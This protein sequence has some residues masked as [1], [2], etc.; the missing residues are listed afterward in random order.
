[1]ARKRCD[2]KCPRTLLSGHQVTVSGSG[3]S[4]P[5]SVKN[6]IFFPVELWVCPA[7]SVFSVGGGPQF[8]HKLRTFP[9]LT[10]VLSMVNFPKWSRS[11]IFCWPHKII[12]PITGEMFFLFSKICHARAVSNWFSID[13]C[14][15]FLI[16]MK[17][18]ALKDG[19]FV[20]LKC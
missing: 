15:F 2:H 17:L 3:V 6:S 18:S 5:K 20:I 13:K 19:L 1:M 11:G 9:S 7:S 8:I 10:S 12:V 16:S 4:N 14:T